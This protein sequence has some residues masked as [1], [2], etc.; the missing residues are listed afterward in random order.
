MKVNKDWLE[1]YTCGGK[2]E[3]NADGVYVCE[4]CGN[5]YQNIEKAGAETAP[6]L[7][8]QLNAAERERKLRHF[9][10]ALEIYESLIRQDKKNLLAYWGAFLSEYGIEYIKEGER[11]VPRIHLLTRIPATQSP[12]LQKIYDLCSE[13]ESAD[14]RAKAA[15]I[16]QLRHRA[17]E[18]SRS[19]EKYDV[20]VFCG[21]EVSEK[22]TAAKLFDELQ[23]AGFSVFSPDKSIPRNAPSAEA[24]VF[25]ASESASTMFVVAESIETLEKNEY[26]W[27]RFIAGEGKKI[28]VVHNGL[29][30]SKFPFR[31]RKTFQK[32]API[33]SN[34]RGWTEAAVTFASGKKEK[35]KE[36][37]KAQTVVTERIV[38][39]D[40]KAD[41]LAEAMTMVLSN[42]TVGNTDGA[43]RIVY[44]QFGRL[45]GE[46]LTPVA[47]LCTELAA[48][49]KCPAAERSRHID[50][51]QNIGAEIRGKYPAL[52]LS[53]RG[54]YG[55]IGDANLLIYLAKCFGAIKDRARQCFVLDMVDYHNIYNTKTVTELVQMLLANGRTDE[56]GEVMRGVSRLDGNALLLAYLKG[57]SGD[58]VQKQ[59]NLRAIADKLDITSAVSD[60]LNAYLSDCADEG[61]ALAVLDI[62]N[63]YKIPLSVMGLG[64]ALSGLKDAESV[65]AV[66]KNFG[67]R[68]LLNVE[69]DKLVTLAAN[70]GDDVANEVLKHL[71]YQ[72]GISD[73]GTYNMQYILEH[74]DLEK[75]KIAFFDFN[76]DKKLASEL[77]V[78]AIRGNGAD[79][80]ATVGIL[81]DSVS[82][83]DIRYYEKMLLGGDPLKKEFMKLLAPKTGKYADAN[84]QIEAFLSGRDSDED[85]R[86]IFAMFG[87]FPFSKNSIG[88]YL[89]ILPERYD[90]TYLKYLYPY[91]EENPAEAR[92][93]FVKHSEK[94]IGGYEE[95]LE[96]IFD[97]V[98]F[99]DETAIGRFIAE[100]KGAQRVKDAIVPKI[101][102]F[103][104]KPKKIETV[105]KHAQCNLLQAY[106]L[107]LTEIAPNTESTIQ[108]L[109]KKGM[110]AGD[111]IF[112]NGRKIKFKE[113]LGLGEVDQKTVDLITQHVKL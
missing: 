38:M 19:Q 25:A 79:R 55:E 21:E 106:L 66:L 35:K 50:S 24:C 68:P 41:S 36:T 9:D 62:M 65:K 16:E 104:D 15:E 5:T 87:D 27:G 6:Q 23:K 84:K 40:R 71:R 82:N 52:T 56:V 48:L 81:I 51:V 75:I 95:Q 33:N 77:L 73:L 85:K 99:F 61:V 74:C 107:T 7:V 2:L 14:Y 94:L 58:G 34:D 46:E 97:R 78:G 109:K 83:L 44:E 101:V 53:E 60:D 96:K 91:L 30:E 86:E 26:I 63:R 12:Y 8:E 4:N 113:Y 22:K 69:V 29:D 103:A 93:I 112:V 39:Q 54:V 17:Y 10:K 1:C 110:D 70:G 32:Q 80:L 100:F 28:Q 37:E 102:A 111:K 88:L 89:D 67:K 57:D 3:K 11:Y 92:G 20:F 43:S 64:G 72:S 108:F 59:L 18:S 42:L 76:I 105:C 90:E 47:L 49:S 13:A 31:L 45:K 98:Q